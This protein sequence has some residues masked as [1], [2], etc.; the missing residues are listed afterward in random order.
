MYFINNNN[1][2]YEQKIKHDYFHEKKNVLYNYF[3]LSF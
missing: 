2:L 3:L 1:Q